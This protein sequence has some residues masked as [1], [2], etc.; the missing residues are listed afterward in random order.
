MSLTVGGGALGFWVVHPD[1][2]DIFNRVYN[3]RS[4]YSNVF[5]QIIHIFL[6]LKSGQGDSVLRNVPSIAVNIRKNTIT[7]LKIIKKDKPFLLNYL[8]KKKKKKKKKHPNTFFSKCQR[9]SLPFIAVLTCY[10]KHTC[11]AR[12]H[13]YLTA[14]VLMNL[15]YY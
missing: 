1:W 9:I 15:F 3:F 6:F 2:V 12:S 11:F 7:N 14:V 5:S 13:Q 10:K 4:I 8:K